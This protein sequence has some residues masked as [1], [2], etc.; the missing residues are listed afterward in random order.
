MSLYQELKRRNVFRVAIAYLAGA[1]LL[2]EVAGTIFPAFGVPEWGVRFVV[3]ILALGFLPVLVFSWVYEITPDGIK[4]ERDVV[5]EISISHHTAKRLDVFTIGVV[6]VA[7][8]FIFL[9]RLWLAPQLSQQSAQQMDVS[10]EKMLA[11]DT[12]SNGLPYSPQSVAV[13]PFANRSANS[14]DVFFVDGIHDDLLSHI[15]KISA[16]K[17]ISRTSVMRYRGSTMSI[18]EIAAELGVAAVLEGG[19]Q[20]A[21]DQVRINVQL[22]DGGTDGHIWSEIYD[23]QLTAENIFSIQSEIARAIATALKTR[24]TPPEQ[25]R[26]QSVPTKSLVAYEAYLLGRQELAK[27]DTDSLVEAV[28][29]FRKASDLD[30][31]F[32]QAWVG[33]ADAQIA[34]AYTA[35]IPKEEAHASAASALDK[36]LELDTQ[37]GE[38]YASLGYLNYRQDNLEAAGRYYDRALELSPNYAELHLWYSLFLSALGRSEESLNWRASAIELD[39]MSAELRRSYAIALREKGRFDDALEQLEVALEIDPDFVGAIDAIA[40]I[41]WQIF[42][43]HDAAVQDYHRL[44]TLNL[45]Q[46]SNY[47]WL[48]QLYLDLGNP[49]RAS[50]LLERANAM[51]PEHGVTEWGNLLLKLY[52]GKEDEV[53]TRSARAFLADSFGADWHVQFCLSQL[54]NQAMAENRL[55]EAR[56]IYSQSRPE[57]LSGAEPVIDLN[58]YRAAIDLALVLQKLADEEKAAV[59]LER[60]GTFIRNQPRLG[61]W[62]GYWIYDVQILA[63]QGKTSEALTALQQAFNEGWRS[64][65][66]YYLQYEPNLDSLREEPEFQFVVDAI[67]KDMAKQMEHV[68]EMERDGEIFPFSGLLIETNQPRMTTDNLAN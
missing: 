23:R 62:G 5:R 29:Y 61:W 13:L 57:L 60:S 48:A 20:R 27:R 32:A 10:A 25:T 35:G 21:G 17:T 63:L 67:K 46:S 1:W 4:R 3:L 43:N 14:D 30:P 8:G 44:I 18:P 40:T 38:A 16:I 28:E 45:N 7:I 15:S 47:V 2:T 31:D 53:A 12:K 66:W 22:I 34:G 36:A 65:W 37:L 54:R 59:L 9:D 58:N 33:L 11:P 24:L 6:V 51:S 26:M 52:D 19:I 56:E 50:K 39:P 49:D 41:Q 68:R 42:N 55:I 64:L